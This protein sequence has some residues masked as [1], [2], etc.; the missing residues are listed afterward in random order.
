MAVTL[1]AERPAVDA[2]KA[3][4]HAVAGKQARRRRGLMAALFLAPTV[5]GITLFTV[6]PIV[7]SIVLAF[8]QWDII[9]PPKFVGLSN[10]AAIGSDPTVRV[11]FLNTF[12]FVVVAGGG[13]RR[14]HLPG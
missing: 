7:A 8:F 14:A 12:G 11:A 6:I 4:L 3:T 10:F 1:P 2:S 5:V 9:S 13:A